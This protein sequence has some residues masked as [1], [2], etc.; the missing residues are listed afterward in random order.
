LIPLL[1]FVHTLSPFCYNT[2]YIL[3]HS[4]GTNAH[5]TAVDVQPVSH[6]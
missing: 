6:P 1:P 3:L 2:Y 5:C 4:K